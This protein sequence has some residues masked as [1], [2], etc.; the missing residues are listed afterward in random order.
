[1]NDERR[2]DYKPDGKLDQIQQSLHEQ[3]LITERLVII[4]ENQQKSIA[5]QEQ[6]R[7]KHENEFQQMSREVYAGQLMVNNWAEKLMGV[8][9]SLEALAKQV[10]NLTEAGLKIRG[11]WI[12]VTIAAGM[13]MGAVTLVG[14]IVKLLGT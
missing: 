6:W 3:S 11:G 14:N 1:M 9:K 12:T 2:Q 7:E 5:S 8:E 4:T 10:T 13:V